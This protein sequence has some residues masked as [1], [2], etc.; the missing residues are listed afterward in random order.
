[1]SDQPE[2]KVLSVQAAQSL[3]DLIQVFADTLD[4]VERGQ[5]AGR[6][7][8]DALRA[9]LTEFQKTLEGFSATLGGFAELSA[10]RCEIRVPRRWF[11]SEPPEQPKNGGNGNGG[12]GS[13]SAASDDASPAQG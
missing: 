4:K 2:Y 9:Q 1:M 7:T 12:E 13:A 8:I 5:M 10:K 3:T 6:E 11:P